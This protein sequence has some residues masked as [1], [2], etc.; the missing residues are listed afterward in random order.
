MIL[1][2]LMEDL[3]LNKSLFVIDL[4]GTLLSHKDIIL[5]ENVEK[6]IKV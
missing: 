5:D 3:L 6:Y 4:D 1:Y 2:G